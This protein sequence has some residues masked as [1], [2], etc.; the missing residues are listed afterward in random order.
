MAN[1]VDW[2]K[3]DTYSKTIHTESKTLLSN[4]NTLK[5]KINALC[6]GND[7]VA[8]WSGDAARAQ[9]G[10]AY[11]NLANTYIRS[12]RTCENMR[13][14]LEY[15]YQIYLADYT[16]AVKKGGD[17]TKAKKRMNAANDRAVEFKSLRDSFKEKGTKIAKGSLS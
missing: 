4:L 10:D 6:K 9:L 2:K 12:A 7:G 5:S 11:K 1:T 17:A 3:L 13:A 16:R 14:L 15:A 8:S